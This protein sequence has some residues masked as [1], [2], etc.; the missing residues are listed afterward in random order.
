MPTVRGDR[1]PSD[2][3]SH[4]DCKPKN[5][6]ERLIGRRFVRFLD[7]DE[8]TQLAEKMGFDLEKNPKFV[9]EMIVG[10]CLAPAGTLASTAIPPRSNADG[11]PRSEFAEMDNMSTGE[12]IGGEVKKTRNPPLIAGTHVRIISLMPTDSSIV[13]R[14]GR[15]GRRRGL[16]R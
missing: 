12:V 10:T 3:I 14:P 15:R 7:P 6:S 11:T 13:G 2:T 4:A 16:A 1:L 9:E 8:L 5:S